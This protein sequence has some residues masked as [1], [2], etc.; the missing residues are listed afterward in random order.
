MNKDIQ[1]PWAGLASYE[2]PEIAERKLKFCGRDDDSYDVAKLI[3]NNIFVTL[4]GKSGI[5]KT[6][7]LNA[8]VFP[9]LRDNNYTPVSLRLGMRDEDHPIS[10]QSIIIEA[11]ERTVSRFEAIDVIPTEDNQQSVDFL[12]K[13]FTNHRFYYKDENTTTL[14]IVFDQ[15][16]EV[17]RNHREEAETLL[18]QLN[19]CTVNGQSRRYETNI[20]FVVSI[21][22]DDLYRLED[23]IDNCYLPTLKRSRYRLRS[24]SEQGARDAIL[25]PGAGLYKA[26]EK[27]DIVKSIIRIANNKDGQGI[28]TNLL[29]LVCSRI[30]VDFQKS[31][32]DHIT[33]ALVDTFIKGN[34]FERFYNEA[35]R[36]FSIKEKS[37]IEDN[38]VDSIGRRNS[39][40]ESDFFL[41]VKDGLKL[42]DGNSRILQRI[43]TSSDGGNC[44]IEL[45]HDSFCEPLGLLKQKRE[46]RRRFIWFSLITFIVSACVVVTIYFTY[47]V[48]QNQSK[49]MTIAT[50]Q[51][52]L[53][54]SEAEKDLIQKQ[55]D[56]FSLLN[57]S[58][59]KLNISLVG[60]MDI[61]EK[62]KD[63][64][65]KS[66]QKLKEKIIENKNQ[67]EKIEKSAEMVMNNI[68][69][70]NSTISMQ[71]DF[72]FE[73][74]ILQYIDRFL[75]AFNGKDLAYFLS[76]IDNNATIIEQSL[77]ETNRQLR[78]TIMGK[79]QYLIQLESL[80]ISNTPNIRV[81]GASTTCSPDK[82]KARCICSVEDTDH[83]YYLDLIF[84]L[85]DS[86]YKIVRLT[87]TP[88]YRY[89]QN[90]VNDV[91][92]LSDFDL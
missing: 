4:Y 41:H 91:F 76:V 44:R 2:D 13:Y 26:E 50:T 90:K 32:A 21:R 75:T 49:D 60:K 81:N 79:D 19:C 55:K 80:F 3:M 70:V 77:I 58:I 15:F 37:Y 83:T 68:E 9:E 69:L 62:Q 71:P 25:T 6:S 61:I 54:I 66:L 24:L 38:L 8:G 14:V 45:I 16:E 5:G 67:K 65:R 51:N 84:D 12:W 47:L 17:F 43:G 42:L 39:V 29:S 7:L 48:R 23:S 87:L 89:E 64:L 59:S 53:I 1:N 57:D 78:T 46:Q 18:R 92:K 34:P 22:E 11:I 31:D 74:Q 35:T 33:P 82:K 30:F 28:S 36:G 40:S 73:L 10:Y 85:S 20:H 88:K 63:S 72:E 56:A 86:V 52:S 27:E